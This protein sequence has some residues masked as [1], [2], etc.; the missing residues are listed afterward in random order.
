MT[1]GILVV[2]YLNSCSFK[3]LKIKNKILIHSLQIHTKLIICQCQEHD[4]YF[5]GSVHVHITN[6]AL[7]LS[8]VLDTNEMLKLTHYLNFM[9]KTFITCYSIGVYTRWVETWIILGENM[10][11][12]NKLADLIYHVFFT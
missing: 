5:F 9:V 8:S 4:I 3:C 7:L 1:I 11:S 6:D 10:R 12:K 2:I